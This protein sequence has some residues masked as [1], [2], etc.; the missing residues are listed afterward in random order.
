MKI[1]TL[2]LFFICLQNLTF[3][4]NFDSIESDNTFRYYEFNHIY[5]GHYKDFSD[6]DFYNFSFQIDDEVFSLKDGSY[7]NRYDVI[8]FDSLSINAIY[9]FKNDSD[10]IEYAIVDLRYLTVGGSSSLDGIV[11]LFSIINSK[12][13]S[14]YLIHY[15]PE[16]SKFVDLNKHLVLYSY[17]LLPDD[18]T[19]CPSKIEIGTFKIMD[20]SFELISLSVIDNQTK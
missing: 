14:D 7:A 13:M 12:L 6:V 10:T 1:I 8:G 4:Q 2:S 15:I 9:T 5:P 16:Q 19:C 3:G 11:I 18:P 20:K 17:K